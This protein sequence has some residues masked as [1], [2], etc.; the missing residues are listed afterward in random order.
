[1][2]RIA[3]IDD[4]ESFCQE[5]AEQILAIDSGF[6]VCCY[7]S[8]DEF[9]EHGAEY[10]IAVIDIMLK[11]GSGIEMASG[12]SS[13]FPLLSVIFVSTE[14]DFFQEVYNTEHIYFMVKPV[15]DEELRR[16]IGLCLKR[17]DQRQLCI[18]QNSGAVFIELNTVLYFE[19]MLKKTTVHYIDGTKQLL[20]IPLRRV[21]DKLSNTDFIRTHQSYIVNIRFV[22]RVNKNILTL[23]NAVI[24]VSRKYAADTKKAISRYLSGG[25]A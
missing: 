11:E 2:I 22:I 8:M 7:Q 5:I 6:K 14:R 9:W 21:D 3:V 16:A 23:K 24:P 20:N 4:D 17:L 13:S 10:N 15:S 12:I 19:G 25:T 1:M 18:Q